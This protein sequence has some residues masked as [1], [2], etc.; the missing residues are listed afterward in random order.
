MNVLQVCLK[1]ETTL[2]QGTERM[3]CPACGAN[4]P[5]NQSIPSYDST[6]YHEDIPRETMHELIAL[7]EQGHWLTA[8]RTMLRDSH[9]EFYDH[10]ADLNR[11]SWIPILPIGPNSTVL[12]V[13]SGL[14]ALT[15]ALALNYHHVV[16]AEPVA[17]MLRFTKLRLDQEGLKNVDLI[18]TTLAGLPFSPDTFDLIVLNGV[19]E[20]VG[21][22]RRSGSSTDAQVAVLAD[23]RRLLKP[24]GV[25]VIGSENRIGY[26]SFLRRSGHAR[27]P[28]RHLFFPWLDALYRRL[29]KS[30]YYRSL[31]DPTKRNGPNT[32]TP[33]GYLALLRQAGFPSIDLWWPPNGYNSPHIMLRA[34]TRAAMT[35]YCDVDRKYKGRLHGYALATPP[36][37]W[38]GVVTHPIHKI[39]PDVIILASPLK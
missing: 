30:G 17:D 8:A 29:Q 13:N 2:R 27:G 7:A 24:R 32:H 34:F 37:H 25:L 3:E 9:P 28:S 23:L 21:E 16:S 36:R 22:W 26:T 6:T 14:G 20:W 1:C 33:R 4:W 19:L 18:Q 10:V 39:F 35:S 38:L 12:D 5:L 11:A 15:H 31:A